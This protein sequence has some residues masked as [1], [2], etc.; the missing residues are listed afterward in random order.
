MTD[1][2]SNS[3]ATRLPRRR[4]AERC[5]PKCHF[6]LC[7]VHDGVCDVGFHAEGAYFSLVIGVRVVDDEMIAKAE[8]LP[9]HTD[10]GHRMP[11]FA[12][13][14]GCWA[15]EGRAADDWAHHY[16]WPIEVAHS[17]SNVCYG[18]D[19][20]DAQKGVGGAE[21][22]GAGVVQG[23]VEGGGGLG[24]GGAPESY[25]RSPAGSHLCL[26]TK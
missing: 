20:V 15:A 26:R 19:G 10:A 4:S 18:Q 2:T 16:P 17:L 11:K 12:H 8:I 13:H 7:G 23:L 22:Q 24:I 3:A 1:T 14:L 21:D 6:I 5:G 9:G 25:R